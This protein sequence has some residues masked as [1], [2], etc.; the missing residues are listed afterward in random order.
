M[1]QPRPSQDQTGINQGSSQAQAHGSVAAVI[2]LAAGG[3]TRMKSATSKLLHRIGGHSLLSYAVQAAEEILPEDLVV[4]IG[5]EREQVAAHLDDIAPRC[6]T[7]V[8]AEQRGTGHAVQCGLSELGE[9]NGEIVVTYGDVPLLTGE[10]LAALVEAH[11]ANHDAVTVLTAQVANPAGYGRIIRDGDQVSRIVEHRDASEVERSVTEINSGIYVFEAEV[12]RAGLAELG[13]DNA[14]GEM[15]LTDVISYARNHGGRVGAYEIDDVWQ[16]EGVNDRV[17]LATLGAELNRRILTK[18][19]HEGVTVIDPN[20]TWIESGVDLAADVTLLPGV[21]LQGATS[22]ATGAVIGPDT[23]LKDVEV[24]ENA[25]VIRTHGEL[26]VIGPNAEVGPFARLRPGSELGASGKIGSF[27][28]T[29][30]AKIGDGAKVSS[31]CYCGDT[32]V[33][34]GAN[35]GAGTIFA[36]YDGQN[37][38]HTHIGARAF[39]GA[40]TVLVAPVDVADSAFV[41]AGSAI[42]ED[43]PAGALSVARGRQ[44]VSEGWVAKTRPG[45]NA[46]W[47]DPT[48]ETP[49][50]REAEQ[51]QTDAV[52]GEV[53]E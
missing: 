25:H 5:H 2:V 43:V 27:V 45:T 52:T 38:L 15:Y 49:P 12:L 51:V 10:T 32:T 17:Q 44:H 50:P 18:W 53:T 16:T 47:G 33:G 7:A 28:E 4:V 39:I 19:M 26:A 24:G 48:G 41:A 30:N 42:T 14:Q 6:R 9:V 21:I 46:D 31:L 37:K 35:I 40:N 13:T 29:K 8:Q 34:A 23:T 20:T 1:D 3:G 11:R 36:N 22:V